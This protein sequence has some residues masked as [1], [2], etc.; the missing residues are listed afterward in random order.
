LRVAI[1][2]RMTE[3]LVLVV[4]DEEDVLDSVHDSL[5]FLGCRVATAMTVAGAR[6]AIARETPQIAICDW[7]LAGERSEA[8]LRALPYE[9]G[10]VLLS[11]SA[12]DEWEHLV[13]EG[14]VDVALAKPFDLDGLKAAL[15]TAAERSRR[16]LCCQS[17][18]RRQSRRCDRRSTASR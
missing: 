15:A 9:V 5:R 18:D 1:F 10:R 16:P 4:D 14:V 11:A 7:N 6:A 2:S 3:V 17:P 12:R 8:L 13:E